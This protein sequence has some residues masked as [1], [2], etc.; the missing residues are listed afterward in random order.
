MP[1]KGT[2]SVRKGSDEL[3]L[4]CFGHDVC[5]FKQFIMTNKSWDSPNGET[6][7]VPKDDG[8]GLM[9]NAFQSHEFG[10]GMALNEEQLKEVN[11]Y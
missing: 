8:Q 2:V 7:A 1:L 4:I 3:P 10:F 5:I 6:A 11:K 9:I